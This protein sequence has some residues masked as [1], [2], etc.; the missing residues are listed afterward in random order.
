MKN[1]NI[2]KL[3]LNFNDQQ[4]IQLNSQS[5]C[6]ARFYLSFFFAFDI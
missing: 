5:L 1:T 3:K 6:S 4:K 2:E